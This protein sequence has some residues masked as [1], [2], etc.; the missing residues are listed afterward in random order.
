MNFLHEVA[1]RKLL[2]VLE[3]LGI[4]GS[5]KGL[6]GRFS[7]PEVSYRKLRSRNS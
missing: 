3:T 2:K 1:K 6:F 7:L 5:L 4:E